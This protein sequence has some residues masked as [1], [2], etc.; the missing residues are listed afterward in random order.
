MDPSRSTQ[1]TGTTVN[2]STTSTS[3]PTTGDRSSVAGK[4]S[5]GQQIRQQNGKSN[6]PTPEHNEQS[7]QH[8]SSAPFEKVVEVKPEKSWLGS[9]FSGLF[10]NNKVEA[11]KTSPKLPAKTTS[12]SNPSTDLEDRSTQKVEAESTSWF[13]SL[14]SLPDWLTGSSVSKLEDGDISPGIPSFDDAKS[15]LKSNTGITKRS[16]EEVETRPGGLWQT[17]TDL[18]SWLRGKKVE[19]TKTSK[20]V[21]PLAEREKTYETSTFTK[22]VNFFASAVRMVNTV[23][24][25]AIS[26]VSKTVKDITEEALTYF[27]GK[28]FTGHAKQFLAGKGTRFPTIN[29]EQ[30]QVMLG[31]IAQLLASN[32]EAVDSEFQTIE[33]PTIEIDQGLIT[34]LRVTGLRLKAR[35]APYPKDCPLIQRQR[36]QRA[37]EIED[38]ECTV[39]L[40]RADQAPATLDIS[41][42]KGVLSIGSNI[43]ATTGITDIGRL[44][45]SGQS[46]SLPFDHTAIQIKADAMRVGFRKLNSA[47]PFDPSAPPSLI[48]PG[49]LG[50]N[51][52]AAEFKD[53]CIATPLSLLRKVPD[54]TTIVQCGGFKLTNEVSRDVMVNMRSIDVSTL[55]PQ[56]SGP[57]KVD[58]GLDIRKVG[59]F[60][61]TSLI[62]KFLLNAQLDCRVNA[63][64]HKGELDFQQLK[65]G[66]KFTPAKGNWWSKKVSGWMNDVI[67]SDNTTLVMGKDGKPKVRFYV[68][69]P[70]KKIFGNI[71]LIGRFI[72]A[73]LPI[74]VDLSL[75]IKGLCPSPD[76]QG[77][78]VVVDLISDVVQGLQMGWF[79]IPGKA[80]LVQKDHEQLCTAAASG[81]ISVSKA[82]T[83]IAG[84]LEASGHPGQAL[85]MWQAIPSAHFAQ[86]S[87]EDTQLSSEVINKMAH[88]MVE[89]DPDKAISLYGLALKDTPIGELPENYDGEAVMNAAQKLDS[90][91]PNEMAVA[92]DVY[93]FLAKAQ[94]KGRAFAVLNQLFKNGKYPQER[95]SGLMTKVI[96][97]PPYG[98]NP[99]LQATL[100]EE[101][102][103]VMGDTIKE[104][105]MSLPTHQLTKHNGISAEETAAHFEPLMLKYNLEVQ[106][107]RMY[108]NIKNPSKACRLLEDCIK[109]GGKGAAPALE[110]RITS[111]LFH[112]SYG[113][114]RY[115]SGYQLLM[116]M[117]GS[118]PPELQQTREHMLK[119]LWRETRNQSIKWP[120]LSFDEATLPSAAQY[121][122]A[123]SKLFTIPELDADNPDKLFK[124]LSDI[125][126]E[127]IE[128]ENLTPNPEQT[129]PQ[130]V[131]L[132]Q[133]VN[134]LMVDTRIN[135]E[136]LRYMEAEQAT[137]TR[138]G[139]RKLDR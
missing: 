105:L 51:E 17:I 96:H 15:P 84:E 82:L 55:D 45:T 133:L 7:S 72:P 134:N 92:L 63:Q 81:N 56:L 28:G 58:V 14:P 102:N 124:I 62:P 21:I 109:H 139:Q 16:V 98:G 69:S 37:I 123:S 12:L 74:P 8:S 127:V 75:P 94:P 77:K 108:Q 99:S 22:A 118:L 79:Q 89:V 131:Q 19:Q 76:N 31:N 67:S 48:A 97:L 39:D 113:T 88:R 129:F 100:L 138:S 26:G 85:R 54:Q 95:M 125:H 53:V 116:S 32:P 104:A 11:T 57:L 66:L 78:V 52:G 24:G 42:P 115:I 5:S 23:T 47:T 33:I 121:R 111:E 25:G 1:S 35:L 93:E 122:K 43:T 46:D 64:L 136:A 6:I 130:L 36:F 112:G 34:P 61:G 128:A 29:D 40:P 41:L 2:S 13:D 110:E 49:V 135:M 137:A 4:N 68:P 70:F 107:A 114:P 83:T 87:R 3:N 80:Q 10:S 38:L 18:P 120:D 91:K 30:F 119:V 106:A 44:L 101:M 117:D 27:T 132:K 71:P 9:W 73:E 126:R 103:P 60:P 90:S 65:A 86:I 50:F 20:G 59:L